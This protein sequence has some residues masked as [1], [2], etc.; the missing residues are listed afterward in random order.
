ATIENTNK[1][2]DITLQTSRLKAIQRK[3]QFESRY[4]TD[5]R[6]RKIK[7]IIPPEVEE[8]GVLA[9]ERPDSTEEDIKFIVPLYQHNPYVDNTFIFNVKLSR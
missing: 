9:F 6:Y 4:K 2:T 7:D 1:N 5:N 8:T 3:R